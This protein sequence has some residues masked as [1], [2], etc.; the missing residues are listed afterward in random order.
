MRRI[1]P[2]FLAAAL[3]VPLTTAPA[4]AQHSPVSFTGIFTG[5]VTT[6]T[7]GTCGP[8]QVDVNAA[9]SGLFLP[10]GSANG[11]QQACV[12]MGTFTFTGGLFSLNF[13][14]GNSLFGTSVGSF[15]MT[16][17]QQFTGS[18]TVTITG[19]TGMFREATGSG[20]THGV[21]NLATG[22]VSFTA[23]GSVAGPEVV[24][25]EPGTLALLAGGLASAAAIGRVSRRR[26]RSA[27]RSSRTRSR[28]STTTRSPDGSTASC[29]RSTA[30]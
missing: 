1:P 2:V 3:A 4:H 27:R 16:A 26:S 22:T 19:G 11:T 14:G 18:S 7:P 24:A 28:T 5:T 8:N 23:T 30:T 25:P 15:V 17:P 9:F 21:Q 13:G 12:N 6:A 29:G 10:F 20:T